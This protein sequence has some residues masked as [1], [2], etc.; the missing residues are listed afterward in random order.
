MIQNQ[1]NK[2]KQEAYPVRNNGLDIIRS[3]AILFVMAGHFFMNTAFK[4]TIFAG[5][6]MFTQATCSTILYTGVPL[7]IMLTGYLNCNKTIDRKYYKGISKVL[8]AY[9]LF[10]VVTLLFRTYYLQEDLSLKNWIEQILR[11]NAIPYGWYIEMW[12]GLFLFTPFLNTLY[13]GITTQQHKMLLIGTLFVMT[14]L[15]DLLNRYGMHVIPGF[16]EQC[17]PLTF[18]FIGTYIREYKPTIRAWKGIGLILLICLINP[19]FNLLFIHNHTLIQIIGS[20]N[21]VF[22]VPIAVI[23]FILCYQITIKATFLKN[24]FMKISLLS[25]DMYLCCYIFDALYYPYFKNHYFINQTQFGIF[26]FLIVP[27]VFVSSFSMA[28]GKYSIQK[29]LTR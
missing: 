23:F 21:G 6:S 16:W 11:F 18:F 13:K 8:I 4:S 15:P 10:S 17:F 26:F 28:W 5:V 22:G 9:L 12:I 2:E 27:L 19:V 1:I 25:L 7:F 20:S 3:S 14:A 24:C 29:L